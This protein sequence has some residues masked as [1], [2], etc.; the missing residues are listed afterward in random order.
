MSHSNQY[1]SEN[2]YGD[3]N[4][5]IEHFKI[6]I[7]NHNIKSRQDLL[8]HLKKNLDL[9]L[10]TRSLGQK[11]KHSLLGISSDKK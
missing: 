4:D 9:N 10:N 7:N 11:L 6:D 1:K 8:K 2:L 5:I 3:Y